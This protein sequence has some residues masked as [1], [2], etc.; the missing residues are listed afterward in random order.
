MS[1]SLAGRLVLGGSGFEAQ[2]E[3]DGREA[4]GVSDDHLPHLP[5]GY[6]LDC[7]S[8]RVVW[9]L[10][11]TA[12]EGAVAPREGGPAPRARRIQGED[13][14]AAGGK[15]SPCSPAELLRPCKC[16][17]PS[18][19]TH[20]ITH[21]LDRKV[22]KRS[23]LPE[24]QA[25]QFRGSA[26]HTEFFLN[27][28]WGPWEAAAPKPKYAPNSRFFLFQLSDSKLDPNWIARMTKWD[29][30]KTS[31]IF[32]SKSNYRKRKQFIQRDCVC[33]Q[34]SSVAFLQV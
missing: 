23:N 20:E 6:V 29:T 5:C 11:H 21:I 18:P 15:A 34:V 8:G 7:E 10:C 22:E 17:S 9:G 19:S 32:K 16:L 24:S 28:C 33:L 12:Q 2:E 27:P 26:V 14:E 3:R 31:S 30:F 13:T 4:G 1:G 25:R